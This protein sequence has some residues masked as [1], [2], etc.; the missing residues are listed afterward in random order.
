MTLV[1][2]TRFVLL[3]DGRNPAQL[4]TKGPKAEEEGRR[5]L[6]DLERR[7]DRPQTNARWG[8]SRGVE[9]RKGTTSLTL[10][11]FLLN[12]DPYL[13]DITFRKSPLW[14]LR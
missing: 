10:D 1:R 2:F 6:A 11:I 5:L 9:S 14:T 13:T 8:Y 4:S 7:E 12:S 3:Q